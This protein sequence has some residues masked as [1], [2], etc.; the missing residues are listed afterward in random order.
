MTQDIQLI[1]KRY[2]KNYLSNLDKLK[3]EILKA[4]ILGSEDSTNKD[5]EQ[6]GNSQFK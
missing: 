3:L 2:L 1:V 6:T 4:S 5:N